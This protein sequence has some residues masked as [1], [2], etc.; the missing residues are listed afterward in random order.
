MP[1]G[2]VMGLEASLAGMLNKS[3]PMVVIGNSMGGVLAYHL[4]Q[5]GWNVQQAF[6]VASPLN[7]SS[8]LRWMAN[9]EKPESERGSFWPRVA[10]EMVYAGPYEYLI[11][12]HELA[13][14]SHPYWTVTPRLDLAGIQSDGYVT[15]SDATL[16]NDRDVALHHSGHFALA[17]DPRAWIAIA[18][19]MLPSGEIREKESGL[20][21]MLLVQTYKA[22]VPFFLAMPVLCA[23]LPATCGLVYRFKHK[24]NP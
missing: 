20:T 15:V 13:A 9:A 14:P 11:K 19:R 10:K 4:P 16:E 2:C 6:Y 5:Y 1:G 12:G 23:V 21:T 8:M 3:E 18:S 22:L 24:Q 17:M 7:G